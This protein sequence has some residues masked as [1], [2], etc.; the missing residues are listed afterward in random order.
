MKDFSSRRGDQPVSESGAAV[1]I[2]LRADPSPTIAGL[3][4]RPWQPPCETVDV[5]RARPQPSP[6]VRRAFDPIGQGWRTHR[7]AMESE[8]RLELE[9]EAAEQPVLPAPRTPPRRKAVMAK[10]PASSIGSET[11]QPARPPHEPTM[12]AKGAV[13]GPPRW[14]NP[15]SAR[16]QARRLELIPSA[17]P[18]PRILFTGDAPPPD[19]DPALLLGGDFLPSGVREVSAGL[20]DGGID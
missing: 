2:R 19:M 18:L 8:L 12:P 14:S 10:P 15:V 13:Q 20:V 3:P 1:E 4:G 17:P 9:P 5:L 11:S 6:W 16:A 7:L